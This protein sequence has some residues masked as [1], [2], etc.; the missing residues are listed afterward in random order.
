V[1]AE[2]LRL[3]RGALA[4]HDVDQRRPSEVHRFVEGAANVLRVLDEEAL[5]AEG[6]HHPVLEGAVNEG[7][8][9]QVEYRVFRDLGHAG[10]DAAIVQHHDLDREVVANE[11]FHLHAGEADRRVSG[12]VD[13]RPVGLG[14]GGGD[15]LAE[16][17]PH[18][19]VGA[20]VE[21]GTGVG[22]IQL[23]EADIHR[24]GA[25]AAIQLA[26]RRLART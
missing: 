13:D 18:R 5:A 25:L 21:A 11:R 14:D 24:A 26:I 2:L 15:G 17:D 8:R 4:D 1:L 20:G 16:P 6:F 22:D 23:G 7:V 10:A 19:A 12:E 9:L 3:P